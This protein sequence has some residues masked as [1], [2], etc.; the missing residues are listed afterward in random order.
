[1]GGGWEVK[2]MKVEE[3]RYI[4]RVAGT[5]VD[6]TKKLPYGL[7]KIRGISSRI[8]DAV[9]KVAGFN[10]EVRAGN[11]TDVEIR[12]L[13]AVVKEPSR[14]GVPAWLL[15]RRKDLET[16]KDVHLTGSDL[17]LRKREDITLMTDT[18]SWK[19]VRHSLGLKVRGQKTRTTGKKGRVV[20]VTRKKLDRR[21]QQQR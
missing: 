2:A 8:A 7:L 15:N 10:P 12:K 14:H 1:L 21:I 20:G 19:G 5:D 11:L 6:G 13:E 9:V 17:A 16:G 18:R 3:F 4:V